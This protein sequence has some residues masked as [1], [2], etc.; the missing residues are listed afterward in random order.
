M[1]I[2]VRY[3]IFLLLQANRL[4]FRRLKDK[5][6]YS[7]RKITMIILFIFQLE[8]VWKVPIKAR[9]SSF[10][11]IL[12]RK[13]AKYFRSQYLRPKKKK[14]SLT[15]VWE[16]TL[17]SIWVFYLTIS[18]YSTWTCVYGRLQIRKCIVLK[19]WLFYD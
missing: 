8:S 14:K 4:H 16:N 17:H 7:L 6:V 19:F 2:I 15:K 9:E 18:K 1:K 5:M 10:V 11:C 12:K 3:F 13:K